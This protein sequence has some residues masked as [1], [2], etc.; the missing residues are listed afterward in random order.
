MTYRIGKLLGVLA[1]VAA[2]GLLGATAVSARGGRTVGFRADFAG[3]AM[4][5][6]ATTAEFHGSGEAS[7]LGA[8]TN[9]GEA[10]LYAPVRTRMCDVGWGI[11]NVHTETLTGEDGDQLVLRFYDMACP[12]GAV[13]GF[14]E[15]IEP[16]FHGTGVFV[17]VGG[18][19]EF[20]GARGLG[21]VDGEGNFVTGEC[22]W[23]AIGRIAY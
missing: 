8:S 5:T 10:T 4:F 22:H 17:V 3:H 23:S 12:I 6:S 20:A 15:V 9:D 16:I 7:Y 18:T 1:V 19:G 2:I 14:G 13:G 21:I 11:P